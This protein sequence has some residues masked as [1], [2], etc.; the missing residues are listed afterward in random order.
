MYDRSMSDLDNLP[1][2]AKPPRQR[3]GSSAY[4][5][6]TQRVYE[7]RRA[8]YSYTEIAN[9]VEGMRTGQAAYQRMVERLDEEL[10]Y[11]LSADH[12]RALSLARLDAVVHD[13]FGRML[14]GD[15]D[16]RRDLLAVERQ[17]AALLGLDAPTQIHIGPPPSPEDITLTNAIEGEVME[18][19]TEAYG[20]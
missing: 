4:R 1:A 3:P 8:G 19:S 11:Q 20:T 7:L 16:A 5:E 9:L 18:L 12:Q 14:A 6:R 15:K 17:R 10:S 13:C 2:P